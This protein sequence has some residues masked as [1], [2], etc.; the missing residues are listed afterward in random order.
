MIS[1]I[2]DFQLPYD[3]IIDVNTL[4]SFRIISMQTPLAPH[5]IS[6]ASLMK[7]FYYTLQSSLEDWKT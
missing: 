1:Y 5:T 6:F 7:C 4:F 3:W 2:Y